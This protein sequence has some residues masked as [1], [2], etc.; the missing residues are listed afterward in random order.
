[1]GQREPQLAPGVAVKVYPN[2][3]EGGMLFTEVWSNGPVPA[4]QTLVDVHG[5]AVRTVDTPRLDGAPLEFPV[6]DLASGI[7][8]LETRVEGVVHRTRVVV[9]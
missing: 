4:A 3:V 2:P 1:L 7:Y 8:F 6:A 5:R 9:P